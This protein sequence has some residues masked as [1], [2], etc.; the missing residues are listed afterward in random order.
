MPRNPLQILS[1][2]KG[3][4]NAV[5]KLSRASCFEPTSPHHRMPQSQPMQRSREIQI[6][7]Y[8]MEDN[9]EDSQQYPSDDSEDQYHTATSNTDRSCSPMQ[10]YVEVDHKPLQADNLVLYR[11]FPTFTYM[12]LI[13]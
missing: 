11:N 7:N 1:S 9:S 3:P 6:H 13:L 10:M 12:F 8:E 2:L 5:S 4:A